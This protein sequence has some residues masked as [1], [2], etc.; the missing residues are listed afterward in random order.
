MPF[1]LETVMKSF[2]RKTPDTPS[3]VK[4]FF[5]SGDRWYSF[6]SAFWKNCPRAATRGVPATPP[7][8]NVGRPRRPAR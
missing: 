5:A 3:M 4:S 8:A 2:P 6:M 1:V 7:V